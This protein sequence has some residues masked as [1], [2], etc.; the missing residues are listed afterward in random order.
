MPPNCTFKT[1]RAATS[2]SWILPQR[3]ESIAVSMVFARERHTGGRPPTADVDSVMATR[4]RSHSATLAETLPTVL[5]AGR[6][7]SKRRRPAALRRPRPGHADAVL[8]LCPHMLRHL[9]L[10]PDPC[11]HKVISCTG[12]GPPPATPFTLRPPL[13]ALSPD[14]ATLG[15]RTAPYKFGGTPSAHASS[16]ALGTCRK[17]LTWEGQGPP[18]GREESHFP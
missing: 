17:E 5:E 13:T 16:H 18:C 2:T 14:T 15:V 1:A 12:P 4:T 6:P 10:R 7:R 11:S 3:S 8:S 9:R